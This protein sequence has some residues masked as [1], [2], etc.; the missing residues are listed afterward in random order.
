VTAVD[1]APPVSTVPLPWD[2][3]VDDPVAALAEARA[4]LGDTFLDQSGRYL[5]LF[6]PAG[7]RSLYELAEDRASK[8]V[9]DFRMLR[10]KVPDELFAGRRT[11]PHELFGRDDVAGYL[12]HLD[13]ALELTAAELG[14]AGELDVFD[15]T[16]R[17]GHRMGLASWAGRAAAEGARFDRLV[18]ALD[19]LDASDAFVHPDLMGAVARADKAVERQALADAAEVLGESLDER[20]RSSGRDDGDDLFGRIIARWDDVPVAERRVGIAHDVVLVHLASMSNLFAGLGWTIVELLARPELVTRVRDGDRALVEAAALESI[21]LHQRSIM[22]R[23]VLDTVRVDDGIATRTVDRGMTIATLLPL[24][25][26]SSAPGLDRWD[27]DRWNGRRLR[28]ATRLPVPEL[29]TAFG[30]GRHTCPA[31]PFSL[32]AITRAVSDLVVRYDLEP[33]YRDPQPVAAQIG[34]VARASGPCP[35]GY[36]ARTAGRQGG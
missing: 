36:V 35:V 15:H 12:D 23:E 13:W 4:T 20:E 30:H 14:A 8:G 32:A 31:Q 2:G 17:L 22:L 11:L 7:V 26:L 24:T 33:R 25:N 34:G 21:R 16:R 1:P 3:A 28:D 18:R 27:P 10:R 6:S 19:A 9:A 5:F 29:V